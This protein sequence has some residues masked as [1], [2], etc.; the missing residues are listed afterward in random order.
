MSL[1]DKPIYYYDFLVKEQQ[2]DKMKMYEAFFHAS[3]IILEPPACPPGVELIRDVRAK[4][5]YG[6]V[7]FFFFL[8]M[9]EENVQFFSSLIW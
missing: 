7:F 4:C 3:A 5:C 1:M 2:R 8:K 6:Q 9:P